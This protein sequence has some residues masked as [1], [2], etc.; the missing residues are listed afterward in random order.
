MQNQKS[1]CSSS[2]GSQLHTCLKSSCGALLPLLELGNS[3]SLLRPCLSG[4]PSFSLQ[5][6]YLLLEALMYI[7]ACLLCFCL[8]CFPSPYKEEYQLALILILAGLK[9]GIWAGFP[10]PSFTFWLTFFYPG[11]KSFPG[12]NSSW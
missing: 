12:C 11:I 2:V 8:L 6:A 5:I 3:S 9:A 1:N 7:Y 10:P 4:F